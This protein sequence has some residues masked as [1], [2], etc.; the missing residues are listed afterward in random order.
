MD[1]SSVP[2][3]NGENLQWEQPQGNRVCILAAGFTEGEFYFLEGDE[4]DAFWAGIIILNPSGSGR[5]W[6]RIVGSMEI[7]EELCEKDLNQKMN[8]EGGYVGSLFIRG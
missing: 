4:D 3:F 1:T 8:S 5:S 6:G 7:G 2:K